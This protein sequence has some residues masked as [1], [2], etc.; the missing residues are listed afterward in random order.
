MP[1]LGFDNCSSITCLHVPPRNTAQH[2]KM[3]KEQ[4][5]GVGWREN[6]TGKPALIFRSN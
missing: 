1:L 6:F 2:S 5:K 3:D 4:L